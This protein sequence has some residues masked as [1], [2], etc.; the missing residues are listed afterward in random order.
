VQVLLKATSR[1]ALKRAVEGAMDVLRPL[2]ER[3]LADLDVDP[4]DL[5]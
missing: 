1:P 3:G 5:L 2:L 4:Y